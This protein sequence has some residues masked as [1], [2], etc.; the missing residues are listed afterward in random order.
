MHLKFSPTQITSPSPPR[1]LTPPHLLIHPPPHQNQRDP[2]HP[3][4]F[5]QGTSLCGDKFC[6]YLFRVS[7]NFD[8][9][10][11]NI[12]ALIISKYLLCLSSEM[13]VK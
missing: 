8:K 3:F 2:T 4:Q 6:Q 12:W 1:P 5:L 7:R 10:W 11:I 13:I 9:I